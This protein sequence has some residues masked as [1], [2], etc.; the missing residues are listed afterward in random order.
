MRSAE[1][2][3]ITG[4]K[5]FWVRERYGQKPLLHPAEFW[6]YTEKMCAIKVFTGVDK[7]FL[8]YVFVTALRAR[9]D[10]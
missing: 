3:F 8:K 2:P 7:F 5:V 9:N 1:R 6:Y 4:D 10:G